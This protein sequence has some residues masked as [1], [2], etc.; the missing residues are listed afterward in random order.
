[1]AKNSDE[2]KG[3]FMGTIPIENIF[4]INKIA[5]KLLKKYAPQIIKNNA[6]LWLNNDTQNSILPD[7][8]YNESLEIGKE[9][10]K[11]TPKI[12][13][14]IYCWPI[15]PESFVKKVETKIKENIFNETPRIWKIRFKKAKRYVQELDIDDNE[16]KLMFDIDRNIC[17]F[18]YEKACK[19]V[20]KI[21]KQYKSISVD[22]PQMEIEG[23]M[24]KRPPLKG[25]CVSWAKVKIT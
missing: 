3:N 11:T 2:K 14:S 19:I 17:F 23:S 21:K 6:K 22:Y 13:D 8:L 25:S 4:L 16:T 12:T 20:N 9:I 15:E 18:E 7:D 24:Y 1:L 10:H 5:K